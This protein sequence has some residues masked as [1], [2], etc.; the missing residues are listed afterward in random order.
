MNQHAFQVNRLHGYAGLFPLGFELAPIGQG[1]WRAYLHA[2]SVAEVAEILVTR[3]KAQVAVFGVGHHSYDR[4]SQQMI[5]LDEVARKQGVSALALEKDVIVI[6]TTTLPT[7]LADFS[8][9]DLSILDMDVGINQDTMLDCVLH[10]MDTQWGKGEGVLLSVAGSDQFIS[11]HDDCY[12][13]A[14]SRHPA[15]LKEHLRFL[16]RDYASSRL[17]HSVSLPPT[18]VVDDYLDRHGSLTI[19]DERTELRDGILLAACSPERFSFRETK[20]YP[21]AE[22]MR[23]AGSGREWSFERAV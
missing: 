1:V 17:G 16:L 22:R 5:A 23:V 14:E 18:E 3:A 10:A 4:E 6:S 15:Y 11:S 20:A 2:Q 19:L 9:Y 7:L 8:H 21:V 13:Y 12:I